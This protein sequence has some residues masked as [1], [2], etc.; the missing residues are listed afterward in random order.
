MFTV[1]IDHINSIVT[2]V[3]EGFFTLE[4][5]EQSTRAVRDAVIRLNASPYRL[6]ADFRNFRPAT[7]EVAEKLREIL[8]YVSNTGAERVAHL[9]SSRVV[10]LQIRRLAKETGIATVARQ[11]EDEESARQWLISGQDTP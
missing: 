2:V 4:E 11:F 9:V 5:M 10:L 1:E 8:R 6:L 3:R 7:P